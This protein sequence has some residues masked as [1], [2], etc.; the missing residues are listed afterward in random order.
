MTHCGQDGSKYL[1]MK[2]KPMNE[3]A[4]TRLRMRQIKNFLEMRYGRNMSNVMDDMEFLVEQLEFEADASKR[5]L[6]QLRDT[7]VEAHM[8][9]QRVKDLELQVFETEMGED[10]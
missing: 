10:L 7:G 8:L 5:Y 3:E 6:D 2:P 1:K 9:K 4:E